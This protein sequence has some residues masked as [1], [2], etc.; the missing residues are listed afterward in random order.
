MFPQHNA[1]E[2]CATQL[3]LGPTDT[4][5]IECVSVEDVEPAATVHEHLGEAHIGNDRVDDKRILPQVWN[6]G[7]MIITIEGDGS[8][9]PVEVGRRRR[10][11][12]VDLSVL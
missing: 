5:Q 9:G 11:G 6:S 7:R 12:S 8:I 3:E 2:Q 4:Y 1:V 10:L